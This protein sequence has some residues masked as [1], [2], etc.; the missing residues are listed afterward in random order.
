MV[1]LNGTHHNAGGRYVKANGIRNRRLGVDRSYRSSSND[2]PTHKGL[3]EL[4]SHDGV[5]PHPSQINFGGRPAEIGQ[6][7]GVAAGT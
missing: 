5:K 7:N 1:F 4:D 2:S 3:K 6:K